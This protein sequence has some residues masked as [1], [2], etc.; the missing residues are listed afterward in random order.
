MGR[1][2]LDVELVDFIDLIDE[3][4]SNRFVEKWRYRFST[5]FLK[6]FQ[7]KLLKSIA[8]Q[9]PLKLDPLTNWFVNKHNY[10]REQVQDFFRSVDIT[11]YYPV[12]SK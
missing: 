8:D 11:I 5:K 9:K 12:I 1:D 3:T 4:L 2:T 7:F 6:L 10:S